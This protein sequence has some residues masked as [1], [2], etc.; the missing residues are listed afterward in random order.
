MFKNR[1]QKES[2]SSF[3]LKLLEKA[4]GLPSLDESSG[5][6]K[7]VIIPAAGVIAGGWTKN[8]EILL[9]SSNGFSL[10]TI[11]G[12]RIEREE[13]AELT[14]R[15][16]SEDRLSFAHPSTNEEIK[17]FGLDAGDGVYGNKEG[18]RIEVIYPW[19]PRAT[20]TLKNIFDPNH[21]LDEYLDNTFMLDLE[22]IDGWTKCGFS[23]SGKVFMVIGSAGAEVF[24]KETEDKI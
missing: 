6:R 2:R 10:T 18:W 16:I 21:R 5:W 3:E 13:D 12:I 11:D 8:E 14:E 20:V 1:K 24:V 9:I 7:S 23:K 15:M 4:K 22:R 19:W 17:L